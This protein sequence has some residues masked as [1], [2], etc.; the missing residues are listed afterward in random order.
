MDIDWI[1]FVI[2]AGVMLYG[3]WKFLPAGIYLFFPGGVHSHFDNENDA[4]L[5]FLQQGNVRSITEKLEALSFFELGVK[6]E[7]RPIWGSIRDLSLASNSTHTFAS[8]TV[9][10]SKTLC[11]FFTPFSGGQAFHTANDG[12]PTVNTT[13][14]IQ[15]SVFAT[16]P[17]IY[18]PYIK[19]T[20]MNSVR[21][22]LARFRIIH[23]KSDLTR[24]RYI[25]K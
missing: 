11:Y 2:A 12:F 19:D 8:I 20:W 4:P 21:K 15:T 6:I 16:T 14:F 10:N 17:Q 23:S 9:I 24:H 7:R 22:N 1:T 25:T 13:D 3:I 5:K 18:W